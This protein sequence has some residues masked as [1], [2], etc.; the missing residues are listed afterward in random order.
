MLAEGNT[1]TVAEEEGTFWVKASGHS[2]GVIT[3]R[4]FVRCRFEPLVRAISASGGLSDTQ[5]RETLQASVEEGQEGA[6]PS[7][8]AFMHAWLLTLPEVKWVGHTHPTALLPLLCRADAREF[9]RKRIF[10]DE[11]VCCGPASCFVPYTDPGLPL[12]AA[13]KESVQGYIAKWEDTP[14]TIWMANHGLISLGKT[15]AEVISGTLMSAKSGRAWTG[16][17]S[18]V[19]RSEDVIN[20]LSASQIERIHTRPDE[21]FRQRLLA[22]AQ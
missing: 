19:G 9:A 11:V 4:G 13:I 12:A 15:P 6:M 1:S 16:L 17:L 10:P 22:A 3:E 20:P 7:V 2:M 5:V 8:E 14:R 18:T 21:H